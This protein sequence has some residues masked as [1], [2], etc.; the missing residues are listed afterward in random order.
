MKWVK[1]RS[2][3]SKARADA[4]RVESPGVGQKKKAR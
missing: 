1:P 4:D 2:V 3:Q